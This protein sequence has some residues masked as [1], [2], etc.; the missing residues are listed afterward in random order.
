ME[1]GPREKLIPALSSWSP[2]TPCGFLPTQ[3]SPDSSQVPEMSVWNRRATVGN[4]T[5]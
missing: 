5:H 4:S 2:R 1:L 3:G